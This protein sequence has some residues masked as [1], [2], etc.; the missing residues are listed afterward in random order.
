MSKLVENINLKRRAWDRILSVRKT[1]VLYIQIGPQCFLKESKPTLK[2]YS[3]SE[4]KRKQN[5]SLKGIIGQLLAPSKCNNHLIFFSDSLIFRL[6]PWR[7]FSRQMVFQRLYFTFKRLITYL[8]LVLC[9]H[10]QI[11]KMCMTKITNL[12]NFYDCKGGCGQAVWSA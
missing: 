2:K 8:M 6:K 4:L 9:F 5:S 3:E 1:C 11:S 12:C 7:T 10:Q